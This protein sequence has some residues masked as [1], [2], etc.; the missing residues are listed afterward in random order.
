MK[1][2]TSRSHHKLFFGPPGRL[3]KY[4]IAVTQTLILIVLN[5]CRVFQHDLYQLRLQT[6]RCYVNAL[7]TSSNPVS[8]DPDEP[9]K[10]SAQVGIFKYFYFNGQ[11]WHS[12]LPISIFSYYICRID[13]KIKHMLPSRVDPLRQKKEKPKIKVIYLSFTAMNYKFSKCLS[14]LPSLK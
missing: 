11:L 14:Y 13:C 8:S 1:H 4:F 9:I 10:I 6:A 3:V 5:L 7:E 2:F 12:V